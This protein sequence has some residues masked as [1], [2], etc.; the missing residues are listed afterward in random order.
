MS[1]MKVRTGEQ[2]VFISCV[3]IVHASLCAQKGSH[4]S[5]VRDQL[6]SV[7]A[8]LGLDSSLAVQFAVQFGVN[9]C[10]EPVQCQFGC[11]PG[12]LPLEEFAVSGF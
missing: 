4:F 6:C 7:G 11:V 9:S 5:S 3:G 12:L 1:S 2:F 8:Q 10:P